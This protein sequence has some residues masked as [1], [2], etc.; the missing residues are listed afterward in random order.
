MN[1]TKRNA[2]VLLA[3]LEMLILLVCAPLYAQTK[4]IPLD[5]EW[6]FGLDPVGA[7]EAQEWFKPGFVN[8]H[9]DK[10]QTPHCFSVDP[11]YHYYTGN[12]W[13]FRVFTTEPA[14]PGTRVFVHFEAVFYHATVWLNG[15]R[16][17]EHEGGYTSFEFDVTGLLSDKADRKN[18]LV[19]R[20]NN[21]WDTGTIPGAKTRVSYQNLN[22]GQLFPWINYGG[23]TRPVHLLV[24][25]DFYVDKAKIEAR[26][27]LGTGTATLSARVFVKNQSDDVT[28]TPGHI[29]LKIYR[30]QRQI[31]VAAKVAGEPVGPR[32]AGIFLIEAALPKES[33]AL[34]GFDHPVMYEAEVTAG[35]D[36]TRVPFGIRSIEVRGTKLLLNGE[37]LSLGGCNRPLDYPGYGS[38]DPAKV[39]EQDMRL[40]KSGGMELS[41]ISHYPTSAELLDLADRHGMLIIG[42]A[43]NWQMTPEQMSNPVMRRKFQAQM[44]EMVERDWNHPSIIAWSL[45]NEY[46]SQ[47]EEGQAWT[48]DMYAFAKELDATRLVTFAS[49]IAG[50]PYIK[51]PEEEASQYVDFISANIYGDH[52]ARLQR[53]HAL[54]PDKP[55]YVSEFGLRADQVKNEQE[56]VNYL[57]RA[58]ADFRKCDFLVGASVWTFN[59]YQ[60]SF[61][62]TNPNGY[63]PFGLVDP[64]R[65]PREMY[66]AWQ[67]EFAP[68]IVTV[69]QTAAG[70]YEARI[71][72][73]S[74]FPS[75]TLRN[76]KLRLGDRV[77]E[78]ET[79]APG[80]SK[81][82]MLT[83]GS[84][85][86]TLAMSLEKPG[87]F[88]ILKEEHPIGLT[89]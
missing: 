22:Y 86:K 57:R 3:Y 81:T 89:H 59:D 9:W 88:T 38:M 29:G 79:L 84:D 27:D 56:R 85:A 51:K 32:S 58:M 41:R 15:K 77:F 10:V 21:A 6:Q 28:W 67:K 55:V 23:I 66:Y 76:Y 25:P 75:Y 16:L 52:L 71:Q 83:I 37:A 62:G 4:K 20:V 74:D 1:Q 54:Y 73:R 53:I 26:P 11:R 48:R 82:F 64:E 5:G 33:V 31:P 63:R 49:N 40:I 69:K 12:A 68:A 39:L 2:I 35:K 50:R 60:S 19:V 17:G 7:G 80:E 43:G 34:W 42:E 18:E 14:A 24:R 65:K 70:V 36:A 13:Y 44:R 45:G 61:P 78:I 46:R 30:G 8:S 47:T 72:A 87:G